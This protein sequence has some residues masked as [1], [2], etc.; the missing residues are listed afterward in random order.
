MYNKSN[1]YST[2]EFIAEVKYCN[3]EAVDRVETYNWLRDFIIESI[4][5]FM[6]KNLTDMIIQSSNTVIEKIIFDV[7]D[8]TRRKANIF[9]VKNTDKFYN[10]FFNDYNIESFSIHLYLVKDKD[11]KYAFKAEVSSI[12][13][14]EKREM[15]ISS[16]RFALSLDS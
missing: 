8:K 13:F 3:L 7:R 14:R 4:E 10:V 9:A 2:S 11:F 1:T 5:A 12:I 6:S 16:P 15:S